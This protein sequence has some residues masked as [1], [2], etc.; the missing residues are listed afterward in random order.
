MKR[1][2]LPPLSDNPI[3]RDLVDRLEK[4]PDDR[5]EAFQDFMDEEV[6]KED[7]AK[8]AKLPKTHKRAKSQTSENGHNAG[9]ESL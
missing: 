9:R 8:I 6:E 7:D 1:K 5:L 3:F 4:L 2:K